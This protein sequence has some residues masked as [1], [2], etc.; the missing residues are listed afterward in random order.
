MRAKIEMKKGYVWREEFALKK[1]PLPRYENG[2]GIP[3]M[4]AEGLR[5]CPN[6]RLLRSFARQYYDRGELSPA[7]YNNLKRFYDSW[8]GNTLP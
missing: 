4:L 8:G 5:L 6:D 7:Q 1:P 3:Q 2:H